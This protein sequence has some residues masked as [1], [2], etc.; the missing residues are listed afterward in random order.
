MS[1]L[2]R[3]ALLV[4]L[5]L[6]LSAC[7]KEEASSNVDAAVDKASDVAEEV[8]DDVSEMAD[9]AGAMAEEAMDDA[10]EYAKSVI[11]ADFEEA[12]HEDVYRKVAGDLGDRADEETIRRQI[13]AG[14]SVF[15]LPLWSHLSA[16][17][18]L[19]QTPDARAA[20]HFRRVHVLR[21]APYRHV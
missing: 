16:L 8:A 4:L 19:A 14:L 20:D 5:G 2:S 12:G 7:S 21:V 10:A 15:P 13:A 3:T 11:K 1:T 9:D 18:R 17:T 6:T